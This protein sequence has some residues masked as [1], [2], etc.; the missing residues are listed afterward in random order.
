MGPG[1]APCHDP[2]QVTRLDARQRR[3]ASGVGEIR[4]EMDKPYLLTAEELLWS[5]GLSPDAERL[6]AEYRRG[7]GTGATERDK[8]WVVAYRVSDHRSAVVLNHITDES[9][10]TQ[11]PM[12]V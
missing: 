3:E 8:T 9:R 6:L 11:G 4:A 5:K 7:T 2:Q 12:L 10:R 1:S